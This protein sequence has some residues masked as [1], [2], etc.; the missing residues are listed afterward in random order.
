MSGLTIRNA[1]E[2]DLHDHPDF[3]ALTPHFN[4]LNLPAE[5]YEGDD[6][7]LS[8]VRGRSVDK[9][10]FHEESPVFYISF[11][12][13]HFSNSI[14]TM[15]M[16]GK[17]PVDRAALFAFVRNECLDKGLFLSAHA[18][19]EYHTTD[20]PFNHEVLKGLG[21]S[22]TKNH[23]IMN[24]MLDMR[25]RPKVPILEYVEVIPVNERAD[26]RDRVRVQNDVFEN[27]NRIPLTFTDVQKEM[28]NAS[29]IPELSLLLRFNGVACAYGQ[30]INNPSG[31][32]LVNFG[33][34][35]E[36][37][38]QGFS[39]ILLD[40]LLERAVTM[41]LNHIMLEV[42]EDN[43]RAVRLYEKHGFKRFYNKCMWI[44]QKGEA[45]AAGPVQA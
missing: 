26:L 27:R 38:G 44:Y 10:I 3:F 13:A 30:I 14:D 15:I 40:E 41:G 37:Q 21:F 6:S 20:H 12:K 39:H 34:I 24:I 31:H 28:K 32:Y 45:L 18:R 33:V 19:F 42:Y 16:D 43:I 9:L 23:R 7:L 17:V 8:R 22:L 1:L 36:F 35:P 25:Q 29:Y 4:T 5:P 11:R 2:S